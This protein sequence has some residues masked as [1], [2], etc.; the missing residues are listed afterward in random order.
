MKTPAGT[1]VA[2]IGMMFRGRRG[3]AGRLH[4]MTGTRARD[5]GFVHWALAGFLIAFGFV[6]GFTIGLFLVLGIVLFGWLW[7]RG[8]TWPHDLGLLGGAGAACLV[9][10]VISAIGGDVSPTIWGVVGLV[11]TT[12]S[13]ATFWWLRCRP[14]AR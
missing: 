3:S 10:A 1:L 5:W 2:S 8:S 4:F 6:S 14:A 13:S 7:R 11:L 9:I 12:T